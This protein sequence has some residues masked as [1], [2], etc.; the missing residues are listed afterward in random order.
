MAMRVDLHRS[1]ERSSAEELDAACRQSFM[2]PLSAE[3]RASNPSNFTEPSGTPANS[4]CSSG[5]AATLP[6]LL[7]IDKKVHLPA[8]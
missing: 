5:F 8:D 4:A 6:T 1:R 7:Q 2:S 3:P